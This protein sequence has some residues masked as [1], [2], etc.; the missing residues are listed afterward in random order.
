[1]WSLRS[2]EA[3]KNPVRSWEAP[4]NRKVLEMAKTKEMEGFIDSFTKSAFG[5][6]RKDPVCVICGS[7]K[8]LRDDFKD[9]LSWRE[10][11]ISHM[12]Q[13]CQ[14]SVFG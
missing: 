14:D 2:V 12:C 5:R 8:I 9:E 13:E 3:R 11:N 1:M 6:T 10:F 4:P 7:T